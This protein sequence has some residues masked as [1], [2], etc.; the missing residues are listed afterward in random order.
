MRNA[1]K[2]VQEQCALQL[3]ST[4][5]LCQYQPIGADTPLT[6]DLLP[7]WDPGEPIEARAYVGD[8]GLVRSVPVTVTAQGVTFVYQQ[9]VAGQAV[10]YYKVF[11]PSRIS[12]PLV[13]NR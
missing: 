12:L 9:E 1:F 10:A 5:F 13:L 6:L 4:I 2:R 7:G 3:V 11:R 8:G